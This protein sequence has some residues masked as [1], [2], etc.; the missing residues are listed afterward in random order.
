MPSK[1]D[2]M[3]TRQLMDD[4]L[5]QFEEQ[6]ATGRAQEN[7]RRKATRDAA[8]AA[9]SWAGFDGGQAYKARLTQRA[10]VLDEVLTFATAP[11]VEATV[12]TMRAAGKPVTAGMSRVF[13]FVSGDLPDGLMVALR[14]SD[15][16]FLDTSAVDEI[17]KYQIDTP[18]AD[19]EVLVEVHDANGQ[20]ILQDGTPIALRDGETVERNFTITR[21][22]D[23]VLEEPRDDD[24][25]DIL[26]PDLLQANEKDVKV[27]L[28]QLGDYPIEMDRIFDTGTRGTVLAQSPQAGSVL[29]A[30]SQIMLTISNGPEPQDN[31]PDLIGEP[32]SKARA[33]LSDF[34]YGALAVDYVDA[35]EMVGLV[36]KQ[37]PKAGTPLADDAKVLICIGQAQKLMPDVLGTPESAARAQ[38][39]PKLVSNIKV[40]YV[41]VTGTPGLVETQTPTA[42]AVV[43]DQ[44]DVTLVI[45]KAPDV[46]DILMPDLTGK[47]VVSGREELKA[48]GAFELEIKQAPSDMTK[49]RIFGHDPEPKT[50]IQSGDLITLHVSAGAEE[51]V[52]VPQL[53]GLSLDRV[54]AALVPKYTNDFVVKYAVSNQ[55]TGTVIDQTPDAGK[56]MVVGAPVTVTVSESRITRN[57]AVMP[58]LSGLKITEAKRQ[59]GKV[60][61]RKLDYDQ[62]A[63]R[64]RN[65]QIV[66]QDPAPGAVVR[67]DET[68]IVTFG[69]KT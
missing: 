14:K 12:T 16:A 48:R 46:Q 59:I 37:T 17:G 62:A 28:G 31:M 67:G 50:P 42:G 29:T 49:G 13:G 66:A 4:T 2:T 65:W 21:C 63:A 3:L 8:N 55:E 40:G 11:E 57:T 9:S 51:K 39:V 24:Q 34:D 10:A 43:T 45:G 56:Q 36:V 15:G 61:M 32:L 26:M 47:T 25:T 35:P 38:L 6:F 58:D 68:V 30:S 41:E 69:P 7:V 1:S 18:C 23:V 53:T 22:G 27:R 5:V 20:L 64:K 44:T 54:K 19:K 52:V 33:I 60:N